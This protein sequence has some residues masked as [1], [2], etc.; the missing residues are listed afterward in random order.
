MQTIKKKYLFLIY[1]I[2]FTILC[3]IV[4]HPSFANHLSLIWGRSGQ[5]GSS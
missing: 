5:D 2:L 1:T 4:L 3:T